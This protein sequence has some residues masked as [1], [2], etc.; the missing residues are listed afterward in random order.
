LAPWAIIPSK[1]WPKPKTKPKRGV[2]MEEN[3]KIIGTESNP[4]RELNYEMLWEIGAAQSDAASLTASNV[5]WTT[6]TLSYQRMKTGEWAF[7]KI[8]SRLETLLGKLP[9]EGLLFPNLNK[10]LDKDRAPKF[11]A[12]RKR[13]YQCNLPPTP[14]FFG[15]SVRCHSVQHWLQLRC[16]IRESPTLVTAAVPTLSLL[17]YDNSTTGIGLPHET[18]YPSLRAGTGRAGSALNRRRRCQ[19]DG[20]YEGRPRHLQIHRA[21]LLRTGRNHLRRRYQSR[22]HHRD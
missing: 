21:T 7:L 4:E 20:G 15:R 1:L 22:R 2:T 9:S 5:D 6:K 12:P 14:G 3:Q 18:H 10:I 16:C 13:H 11:L 8:G 19:L 17:C